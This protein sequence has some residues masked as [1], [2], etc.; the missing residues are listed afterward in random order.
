MQNRSIA[1]LI[2]RWFAA[3]VVTSCL[4]VGYG[5]T[6]LGSSQSDVTP[7]NKDLYD[8]IWIDKYPEMSHETW[9]AYMF[10]SD[11]VGL[12]VDAASAFKITLEIFEFKASAKD[13]RFHFPHDG[14]KGNSKYTV[15]KL[16]KPNKHFDTQLT[17]EADPQ[18]GGAKKVYFTGPEFRSASQLPD[19]VREAL[20]GSR[21][22]ETM[23]P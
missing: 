18:N 23:A 19:F 7:T 15:E 20:A 1:R 2:P 22:L 3:L 14:R 6:Q 21:Y 8:S 5:V 4:I 16:K 11:N 10:T 9:K 12:N 17:L 13:I